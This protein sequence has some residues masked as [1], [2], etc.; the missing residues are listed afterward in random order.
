MTPIV[1]LKNDIGLCGIR[2]KCRI[3]VHDRQNFILVDDEVL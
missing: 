1:Q 3:T 2:S